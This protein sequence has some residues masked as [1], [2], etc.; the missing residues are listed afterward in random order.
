M[1]RKIF[2]LLVACMACCSLIQAYEIKSLEAVADD[3]IPLLQYSGYESFPYDISSLG[4]RRY[5]IRFIVREYDHGTLVSDDYMGWRKTRSNMTLVSD[6]DAEDQ[7]NIKPEDMADAERGIYK[8]AKKMLIGFIPAQN[9]SIR[10]MMLSVEEMGEMFIPLKMKPQ[11][12]GNDSVNGKK[13]YSYNSRPFVVKELKMDTFVP[14]VLLGSMWYDERFDIHRFCGESV[15][16][17]D[18][19]A[20]ILKYIPHYYVVGVEI[21][22]IE[23]EE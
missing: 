10:P 19:S 23:Q 15:L 2:S 3:Y 1:R 8:L 16:D 4:D 6:F 17:P 12:A 11:Y 5:Q 14:L 7:A 18:M 13:F 9:D 22:P 20:N 21:K